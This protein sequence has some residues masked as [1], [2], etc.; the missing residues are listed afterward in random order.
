MRLNRFVAT[1]MGAAFVVAACGTSPAILTPSPSALRTPKSATPTIVPVTSAPSPSLAIVDLPRVDL[2]TVEATA[3]C[4]PDPNLAKIDAGESTIFCPDGLALGLAVVRTRTSDPVVRLYL[5]RPLCA[6][7]PCTERELST[8]EITAWTASRSYSVKLD[9]RLDTV[10]TPALVDDAEWPSGTAGPAPAPKRQ[11]ITGAPREVADREAYP[12]CGRAELGHPPE[13]LGCFRDAVLAGRAAEMIQVLY[14]TEGGQI[15][16]IYRY[17][18]TG[19]LVFY[20][21]EGRTWRRVEGA[22]ILGITPAAWSVDPW[23]VVRL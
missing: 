5:R 10:P 11:P 12:F 19:R 3:V 6:A 18:G 17:G 1:V 8:A 22:M 14:G 9:S 7:I 23:T 15:L 2:A 21:R 16:R 4:D 13:V 20:Q